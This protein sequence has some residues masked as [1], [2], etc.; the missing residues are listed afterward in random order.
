L[1]TPNQSAPDG[2]FVLGSTF[3]QD[4]TESTAKAVMK[5]GV[6][7]SYSNAQDVHN[8]Q[9][10][11]PLAEAQTATSDNT[12][13]ISDLDTRIA[14]LESGGE[15]LIASA[16]TTW[17]KPT[18]CRRVRPELGGGGGGGARG[19]VQAGSGVPGGAGASG[20]FSK[21]IEFFATD[22]ADAVPVYIG[23]PGTGATA[24]N[25]SGTDG[26]PTAFGDSPVYLD[27]GGGLAG[28]PMTLDEAGG[29]N[30]GMADGARG[31]GTESQWNETGGRGSLYTHAG[32]D[33]NSSPFA[34]G[35]A[36]G[37]AGGGNGADGGS[38]A[39]DLISGP[40]AGGGGGGGGSAIANAGSA[41]DGGVPCGGG[42]GGGAFY[43]FGYNGNG[44]AGGQ[45][46]AWIYSFP[47]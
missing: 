37:T 45:G 23:I 4:I 30:P 16:N 39:S 28:R 21:G 20:G 10:K 40:G 44:G 13:A 14:A 22:V 42:G 27:A 15:V 29:T 38:P 17:I 36:G 1:T 33:G 32:L 35:G 9:V 25:T 12:L 43:T 19:K 7:D 2:A 47:S 41:G 24:D 26:G 11:A 18:W 6:V 31:Y 3:G 5:G 8:E 46:R 34:Q